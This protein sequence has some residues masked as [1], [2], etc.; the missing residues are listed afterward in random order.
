VQH[1]PGMPASMNDVPL[2][3]GIGLLEADGG[4]THVAPVDAEEAEV[5]VAIAEAEEVETVEDVDSRLP[6]EPPVDEAA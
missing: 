6:R 4:E 1:S 5:T 2:W 3:G